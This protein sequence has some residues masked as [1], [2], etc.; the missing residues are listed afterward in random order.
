MTKRHTLLLEDFA[1]FFETKD[2][3]LVMKVR[4]T[5]R[6]AGTVV[7]FKNNEGYLKF[8]FQGRIVAV[9]RVVFLLEHGYCPDYVDHINGDKSDNRVENLRDATNCQNTQNAK[10]SSK[11]TTGVKG[12]H[13]LKDGFGYQVYITANGKRKRFGTFKDFELAE[14]VAVEARA[15]Y[16]GKFANYG[17]QL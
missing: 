14:L 5:R 3:K 15:K 10:M 2:G 1:P 11:N 16:H 9:H 8:Y 13:K 7:G 6:P 12:V 17:V 4:S